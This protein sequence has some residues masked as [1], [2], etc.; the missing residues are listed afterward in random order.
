MAR[1]HEDKP[2]DRYMQ[3]PEYTR[4]WLE[5]ID[6]DDLKEFEEIRNSYVRA[7]TLGWF[8]KWLFIS[9]LGTFVGVVAFG[10]ALA[11]ALSWLTGAAKGGG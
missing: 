4:R 8:F 1:E 3:L 5:R 7:R 11:K 2:L 9:V 10:E 6:E